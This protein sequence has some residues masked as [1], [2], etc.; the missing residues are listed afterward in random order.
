MPRQ[1]FK[2]SQEMIDK[3]VESLIRN[4]KTRGDKNSKWK[5]DR[6]NYF[7]IHKWL[8]EAYGMP[9]ECD[10]ADENCSKKFE[11]ASKD[12]KGYSRN[13]KNWLRLCVYNHHEYDGRGR[14]EKGQFIKVN[15]KQ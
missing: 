14:N 10:L 7:T 1:G 15:S 13:R 9:Q 11:W 4:G 5:G 8:K 2:Q 3:R 12:H 6:A